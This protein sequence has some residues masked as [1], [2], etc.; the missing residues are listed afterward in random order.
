[1]AVKVQVK[2]QY[3]PTGII[4]SQGIASTKNNRSRAEDIISPNKGIK[5]CQYHQ[6]QK[7]FSQ[8]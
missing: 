4:E 7:H 3:A 8:R 5:P 6:L 2:S 1:M